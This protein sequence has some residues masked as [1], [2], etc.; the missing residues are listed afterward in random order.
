MI[1]TCDFKNQYLLRKYLLIVGTM[2]LDSNPAFIITVVL[3]LGAIR[4]AIKIV[5]KTP[6]E[7]ASIKAEIKKAGLPDEMVTVILYGLN[8]IE[9]LPKL[10]LEQKVTISRLKELLFGKNKRTIEPKDDKSKPSVDDTAESENSDKT[11]SSIYPS[12]MKLRLVLIW[13]HFSGHV[14]NKLCS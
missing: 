3:Q 13:Q 12:P 8:L 14:F 11:P 5:E 9:W 6:E 2:S 4:D 1:I 10:I 7:I